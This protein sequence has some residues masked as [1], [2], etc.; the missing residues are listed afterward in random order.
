[1]PQ[2][3]PRSARLS[4]GTPPTSAGPV[5][6]PPVGDK[7]SRTP[8]RPPTGADDEAATDKARARARLVFEQSDDDGAGSSTRKQIASAMSADAELQEILREG[9]MRRR[10]ALLRLG[11]LLGELDAT[12]PDADVTISLAEFEALAAERAQQAA[13]LSEGSVQ[14]AQ[15]AAPAPT[16]APA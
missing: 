8:S 13:G 3:S 2:H 5:P 11:A 15:A 6:L 4:A 9:A 14:G 7:P 16:L 10:P 1:M 12:E